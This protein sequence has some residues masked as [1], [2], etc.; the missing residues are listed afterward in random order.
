MSSGLN[1]K[2]MI[3]RQA[4]PASPGKL[5]SYTMENVIPAMSFFEMLDLLNEKLIKQGDVPIAFD[6]DCRE[7]IC[8][9]CGL[10]ING[11]AH[12]PHAK[13]A[14]C[15]VRMRSFADGETIVVEPF[16][17]VSFP[18]IKDLVVDRTAL[19]RIIAAGGY[20]STNTGSAPDANSVPVPRNDA[21]LAMDA[22]SCIGCGACVAACPNASASLFTGAK[23]SQYALLPQG[24]VEAQER[25]L[26]MVERMDA[27][28]F[29]NCSNHAE[30][31]A[32]CPKEIRLEFIARLN[33]D[34]IKATL[35]RR[36]G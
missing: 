32:V 18:V 7:G 3:W 8:G 30:C 11:I 36:S 16:R 20:V 22:A 1:L 4:G 5:V 6:S 25:A 31:E 13:A 14:S 34:Y 12:G 15:E 24:R 17:A 19:D 35:V 23:I 28:G 21:E 27:E 2:L 26:R 9:T 10:V 29:G 33:R